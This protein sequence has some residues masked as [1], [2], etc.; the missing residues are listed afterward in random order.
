MISRREFVRDVAFAGAASALG[1]GRSAWAAE[2]PPET[3]SI[4]L[5]RTPSLCEAPAQV[6]DVLLAAE[7]FTQVQ[8]VRVGGAGA[9]VQGLTAGE[10]DLGLLALPV[11]LLRIDAGDP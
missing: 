2:P 3:R 8:Y 5:L 1:I 11:P 9:A 6:A 4:R 7:G 10:I